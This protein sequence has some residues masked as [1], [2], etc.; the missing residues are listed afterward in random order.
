MKKIRTLSVIIVLFMLFGLIAPVTT[1]FAV[2][3]EPYLNPNI[4]ISLDGTAYQPVDANGIAV[5]PILYQGTTYLPV[6]GLSYM[7]GK[8]IGW[9]SATSTVLI[10]DDPVTPPALYSNWKPAPE[11]LTGLRPDEKIKIKYNGEEQEFYNTNNIRV[12][13]MNYN[14]TIYLP[15]R[16]FS[17]MLK[18]AVDWNGTT[19]TVLLTTPRKLF[20]DELNKRKLTDAELR[21]LIKRPA[22][23]Q[24]AKIS[25]LGDA[26][27]L[28]DMKYDYIYTDNVEPVSFGINTGTAYN[29]IS[30]AEY[31]L[32]GGSLVEWGH[33]GIGWDGAATCVAY[34]LGD[35][36]ETGSIFGTYQFFPR[37][38]PS[39]TL[40]TAL[41]YI[42]HDGIY[43][44]FSALPGMQAYVNSFAGNVD[45]PETERTSLAG[46]A[47]AGFDDRI[48]SLY[49]VPDGKGVGFK[50]SYSW[51]VGNTLGLS[52]I[53]E[54]QANK[55]TPEEWHDKR[56]TPPE[57]INKFKLSE[58]LGG[59]TM[60]PDEARA[61]V[62]K[63]PAAIKDKVK[64]AGDMLLYM[65]ASGYTAEDVD[66]LFD[67]DYLWH[68]N[69]SAFEVLKVND[70]N[71]GATSNL[72]NYLLE[73]DYEEVG[74]I[75]HSFYPGNGGGHVYNYIKYNG[76]YYIVDFVDYAANSYDPQREF[77]ILELNSL[78]E[79]GTRWNKCYPERPLATIIA[80]K[81]KGM[82]LPNV[83]TDD[84]YNISQN[85]H[86]CYFPEGADF[87]I[88][89][90]TP[91]TGY[92]VGTLPY[93]KDAPD[94]KIPQD[95]YYD[96]LADPANIKD[97][98]LYD[99]L[100]GVTLTPEAAK[101][102]V[103][104]S[105]ETVKDK[106]KTAGD[107]LIYMMASKFMS[108]GGDI[109]MPC[110]DANGKLYVWHTNRTAAEAMNLGYGDCGATANMVN[111]LLDGKYDE[112]GFILHSYYPGND[113]GHVYNYI[114]YDGKYYILD[115]I[116]YSGNKY[117][118]KYEPRIIV[119]DQLED[120]AD[121]YGEYYGFGNLATIV[122]HKSSG[123]HMPNVWLIDMQTYKEKGN[124]TCYYPDNAEFKIILQ[125]P[126][127]GYAIGTL[128]CPPELADWN[129][130]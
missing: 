58:I 38:A 107:V 126:G 33:D 7:L 103:G 96:K 31:I 100:G 6:R 43:Y 26:V 10:T 30:S 42:K 47:T 97:F 119:L 39:A 129:K 74:F 59:L 84:G 71:C 121:R 17:S 67:A 32:N 5:Y 61:L 82:H 63:P 55:L 11:Y 92:G 72:A 77:N 116:M 65:I 75:L 76:K 49:A 104:A 117:N 50:I 86:M 15:V 130:K 81:S 29:I 115:Y 88:I 111:Y 113:G 90:E 78:E 127:T 41:N 95:I 122:A 19:N 98:Y 105:P 109:K 53:Y 22:S 23:E 99:M 68:Y 44:F 85:N 8:S 46:Y 79:Y 101:S 12:Y 13:P 112:V 27:A 73:G 2:E 125:T 57:D 48:D 51:V 128:P 25:T 110:M 123:S 62:G 37:W 28:L 108:F 89:L 94:Y 4:T 40:T 114:K 87:K 16:G 118:E 34:L 91:G 124:Y 3:E 18:L 69:L 45:L 106:V 56:F 24:R 66:K 93:P 54:N 83:W 9:D 60:T 35:D 14:G 21:E 52:P 36:Y 80:H 70:G 120:Y 64:T 102:L 1:T 20:F